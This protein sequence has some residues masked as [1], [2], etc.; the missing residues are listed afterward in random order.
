MLRREL[1]ERWP[2]TLEAFRREF[3]GVA[4]VFHRAATIDMVPAVW[5]PLTSRPRPFE[6][7]S[8]NRQVM[9]S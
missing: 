9:A 5:I 2:Q 3:E 1:A 8:V 6:S 4:G 7:V